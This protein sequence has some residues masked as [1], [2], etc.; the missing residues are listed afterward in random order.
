M[1]TVTAPVVTLRIG[2]VA[3]LVGTTT[4]T[5][6]YYEELGLLLAPDSPS[7]GKHRSYSE[8]EVAHLR[9]VLRLKQLLNVSLDELKTLVEA[10]EARAA[11]RRELRA[12]SDPQRTLEL[13]R[14][15]VF[16]LTRQLEL[17]H[18]RQRELATLEAD[19]AGR[20]DRVNKRISETTRSR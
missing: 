6:R 12:G 7:V 9:E 18:R 3:K 16:H 13:L 5:I 14:E 10:E 8:A 17:V 2:D 20:L 11:L 19:L 15:A 1:S 4:R